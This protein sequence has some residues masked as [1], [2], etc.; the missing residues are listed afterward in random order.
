LPTAK[1][2]QSIRTIKGDFRSNLNESD[3]IRV[4]EMLVKANSTLG[5]LKIVTPKISKNQQGSTTMVFGT[6]DGVTKT[7]KP[8]TNWTG[9]VYIYI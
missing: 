8:V 2:E 7:S 5:Y 6:V 1:R 3:P 9:R 4:M